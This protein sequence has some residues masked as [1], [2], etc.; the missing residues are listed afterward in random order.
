MKKAILFTVA[1][2]V[3]AA[4]GARSEKV[5]D[6]N[7]QKIIRVTEDEEW[8]KKGYIAYS[9][10]RYN[11]AIEC[12]RKAIDLNPNLVKAQYSLGLVYEKQ[13]MLDEAISHYKKALTINPDYPPAHYKL[14][15]V[16]LKKGLNL[17]GSEHFYKA[18]IL[19]L[20]EG[21]REWAEKA[22]KYLKK[23]ESKEL[24]K[25]LYEHLYPKQKSQ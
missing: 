10:N 7:T 3:C 2:L 20:K 23:T 5:K 17:M 9:A 22:Y 15:N 6:D 4:C 1:F 11:Y 13:N 19:F 21:N 18:G 8:F 14:G 24:E 16:F 25:S 12:F